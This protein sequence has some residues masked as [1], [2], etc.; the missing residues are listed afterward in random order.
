M[1]EK[2]NTKSPSF[3]LLKGGKFSPLLG[4]MIATA[5]DAVEAEHF[6]IRQSFEN[7]PLQIYNIASDGKIADLNNLA[8]RTLGYESK[9][10]LIGK[11]F[12]TIYPPS[13]RKKA[14]TLFEK[15]KK[16]GKLH[17]EELQIMTK[18]GKIIDVLLNVVTIFDQKGAPMFKLWMIIDIIERKQMEQSLQEIEERYHMVVESAADSIMLFDG[19]SLRCL[20]ANQAACKMYGYSREE[21]CGLR[22]SDITA[23]PEQSAASIRE[24]LSG[25]SK[26]I[27]KRYHRRKDGTIFPVE[28]SGSTFTIGDRKMLCGIVRD[29]TERVQLEEEVR[30]SRA[31][32][33]QLARRTDRLLVEQSA[34]ISRELHDD[35]G[36]SLTAMAMDLTL[37]ERDLR[38][39]PGSTTEPA[40]SLRDLRSLLNDLIGKVSNLSHILHP[41]VLGETGIVESL[42]WQLEEF[43]R[44]S[45]IA[46]KLRLRLESAVLPE[47][48]ALGV[49]R[50]V[51]EALTNCARHSRAEK[52]EIEVRK[53]KAAFVV[54]VRDNGIGFDLDKIDNRVGFGLLSMEERAA[55]CGGHANIHSQPGVGTTITIVVPLEIV[56]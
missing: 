10:E 5:E 49:F 2:K 19:E 44:R 8:L 18:E 14:R 28:I 30:E 3:K 56:T 7:L 38:K 36:Q 41:A 15:A 21:F 37:V 16:E 17:N 45:G 39:Q 50:C 26:R 55:V 52:V 1:D 11:P 29:I 9:D 20:D 32:F 25:Q 42:A 31:R 35:L 54:V 22:H 23:E 24:T 33:Q 46:T 51:Q 4:Y 47:E 6:K 53:R 27:P 34:A 12:T 48:C 43:G 13:S 40:E